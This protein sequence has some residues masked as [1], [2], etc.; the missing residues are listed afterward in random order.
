MAK[1]A[2]KEKISGEKVPSGIPGFDPLVDGGFERGSNIIVS[3]TPGTGKTTFAMQFLVDGAM[4]GEKCLYISLSEQA[5]KVIEHSNMFGWDL[6]S[7][8]KAKK[9]MIAMYPTQFVQQ[10][11]ESAARVSRLLDQIK[12]MID[13]AGGN[14]QRLVID[15][16]SL[17]AYKYESSQA[18][19]NEL[20]FLMQF[21]SKQNIT[22]AHI[23]ERQ[24]W[25]NVFSFEDF[26]ADSVIVLQDVLK[27]FDR[28]R[29]ISV[30]KMRGSKIDRTVRPY[31][32]TSKGIVVYPDS[33]II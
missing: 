13:Q 14:I 29:G 12:Y 2:E 24:E 28:K 32:I 6:D 9:L 18:Q 22:T 25:Q 26:L 31:N 30:I 15:S 10:V 19:R 1:K 17:L 4:K 21:L 8:V 23:L 5:N 7:L 11:G 33:Q 27:D 3:G 16:V 20:D